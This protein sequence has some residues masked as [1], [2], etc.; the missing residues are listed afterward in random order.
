MLPLTTHANLVERLVRNSTHRATNG[1]NITITSV[2]LM[3]VHASPEVPV[4]V[5]RTSVIN[6]VD[7]S[8]QSFVY[9]VN[10]NS[11]AQ[12]SVPPSTPETFVS[13][14]LSSLSD[15]AAT[16]AC[17]L[18]GA[19][20]TPLS[21]SF[22]GQ[23]SPVLAYSGSADDQRGKYY[24]FNRE[25]FML[26]ISAFDTLDEHIEEPIT[27]HHFTKSTTDVCTSATIRPT[28]QGAAKL[29]DV[30]LSSLSNNAIVTTYYSSG[31]VEGANFIDVN[32]KIINS[33][34]QPPP[35]RFF[36]N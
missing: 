14:Q 6:N 3:C 17:V 5:K 35:P 29:L 4:P 2:K 26:D 32:Y 11:S 20:L 34:D 31:Y 28:A 1:L 9:N 10:G 23:E 22:A 27:A 13:T 25:K 21:V 12:V 36:F 8:T 7:L 15:T 24:D 33:H 19:P 18:N 30:Y 16:G